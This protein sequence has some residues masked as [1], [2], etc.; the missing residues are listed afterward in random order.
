MSQKVNDLPKDI[1]SEQMSG[2]LSHR[3]VWKGKPRESIVPQ[4]RV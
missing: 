4:L 3:S 1:S 2:Q